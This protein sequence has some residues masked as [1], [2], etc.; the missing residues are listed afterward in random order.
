M[1][2]TQSEGKIM[3]SVDKMRFIDYYLG[4]P[5]CFL[6]TV[7]IRFSE[8]IQSVFESKKFHKPESLVF[9]QLSEMGSV[10]IS[11]PA[12]RLA[13]SEGSEVYFV[14][15][16][17]NADSLKLLGNIK[18]ANVF[19]MREDKFYHLIL[20]SIRFAF[21]CRKNK[22]DGVVD[23]EL[24][25]RFSALLTAMSG[26]KLRVGFHKFHSEGLYRGDLINRKVSYNPH[27]HIAKN[28][29]ALVKSSFADKMQIPFFKGSITDDEIKPVKLTFDREAVL[30]VTNALSRYI[31][32]PAEV[33]IIIFNSA[34]GEFLP[35]RRWP[36]EYYASLVQKILDKHKDFVILLT[37]SPR[38]KEEVDPIREKAQRDRCINFAGAIQFEDLPVLYS[39]SRLML[40]NDSG[41]AHFASLTEIPTFV[42]FGPETPNLY[43][44]LGNFTPLYAR[45]TCSPCVS[46][47]NHRKTPCTD[48]VCLQVISPDFV[49]NK[50]KSCIK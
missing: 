36:V 33:K 50:I 21:W 16:K 17:R 39:I 40:S 28:F 6:M 1:W 7:W 48:N 47:F 27:I 32:N 25:S 24:F 9:L 29:M 45:L 41:P 26:C 49:Y 11:D 10:V 8:S 20:D 18:E 44:S 13:K 22:I 30:R 19:L 12:I 35:Q 23:F 43:G 42:F 34:G 15:F 3:T 2:K 14:I 38:E 5:L 31:S 4:V 46:A 37:G